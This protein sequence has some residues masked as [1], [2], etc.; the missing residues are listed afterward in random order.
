MYVWLDPRTRLTIE[1]GDKLSAVV[2]KVRPY[3]EELPGNIDVRKLVAYWFLMG[4]RIALGKIDKPWKSSE[5][6]LIPTHYHVD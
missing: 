5:K 2:Q 3:F 4:R 1:V 6:N